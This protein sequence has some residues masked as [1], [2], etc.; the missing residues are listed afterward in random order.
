[1]WSSSQKYQMNFSIIWDLRE[2]LMVSATTK[3]LLIEGWH[4]EVSSGH[5]PP[6]TFFRISAVR[7][8]RAQQWFLVS[9]KHYPVCNPG[10][11]LQEPAGVLPRHPYLWW[12]VLVWGLTPCQGCAWG[13]QTWG[14]G[15]IQDLNPCYWR[16]LIVLGGHHE[17]L[18]W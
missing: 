8:W 11:L 1:M 6:L 17:Y 14:K 18:Q 12:H 2:L 13:R 10:L 3:S 7:L 5:P 4:K 16:R 9:Q 15:H